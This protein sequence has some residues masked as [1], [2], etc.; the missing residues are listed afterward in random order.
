[1][2]AYLVLVACVA[3]VLYLLRSPVLDVRLVVDLAGAGS[4]HGKPLRR[5]HVIVTDEE[6]RR[7][8]SSEHLF[9]AELHPAGPPVETPPVSIALRRADYDLE[10]RLFYGDAEP[11]ISTMRHLSIQLLQEGLL[12]VRS[13]GP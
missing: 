1:M 12:R 13:G 11:A 10:I 7:V 3:G 6:E 2:L 4:L 9:P 8:A 5:V